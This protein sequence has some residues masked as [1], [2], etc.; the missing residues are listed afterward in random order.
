[1]PQQQHRGSR[2]ARHNALDRGGGV[3]MEFFQAVQPLKSAD[4]RPSGVICTVVKP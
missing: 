3:V 4:N 1:M 2:N